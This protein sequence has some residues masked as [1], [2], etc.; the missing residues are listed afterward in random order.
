MDSS[1]AWLDSVRE[2]MRASLEDVRISS[3]KYNLY[4]GQNSLL[5]NGGLFVQL[6]SEDNALIA[7]FHSLFY[8]SHAHTDDSTHH[9]ESFMVEIAHDD[10]EA[11]VLLT[12]KVLNW[13]LYIFELH[14]RRASS[15]RV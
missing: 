5:T 14:E 9:N 12:K 10:H 1:Q 8:Y 15:S 3:G 4:A 7:P 11:L 2:I 13:D 6:F